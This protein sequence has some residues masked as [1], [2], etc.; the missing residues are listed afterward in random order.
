MAQT[1][2]KRINASLR[3]AAR[4]KDVEGVIADVEAEI[5][6]TTVKMEAETAK[7]IDP[8][9]TTPEAR[10]ARNNAADFE[11]DI[12]RLNASL[13]M[14]AEK[15]DTLIAENAE[16]QRRARYDAAKAERDDLARH[17]RAR[18][19]EIAAELVAMAERILASNAQC[20]QANFQLPDGA[21]KLEQAEHLARGCGCYWE[22]SKGGGPV[23]YISQV[24]LPLLASGMGSYLPFSFEPGDPGWKNWKRM[25]AADLEFAKQPLDGIAPAP[26]A[27]PQAE[28]A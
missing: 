10:E 27:E 3:S 20:D 21:A 19:P 11:H 2:D 1:L 16:A 6:A 23:T 18:Y 12:R 14:L 24:R 9:L 26:E 15:R 13:G 17:I 4:L 28:A 22:M 8:A 25:L 5:A 7:S